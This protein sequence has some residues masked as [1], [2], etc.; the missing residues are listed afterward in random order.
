MS[1]A[2][3]FIHLYIP[4]SLIDEQFRGGWPRWKILNDRLIGR[5]AWFDQQLYTQGAM[6]GLDIDAHAARW[7]NAFPELF[8]GLEGIEKRW[9]TGVGEY[10]AARGGRADWFHTTAGATC[11]VGT[12]PDERISR[13]NVKET[14]RWL[15]PE[16]Y[17]AQNPTR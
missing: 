9:H 4:M 8:A 6:N 1:V 2:V 16:N 3:E 10:L 14:D 11:L 5:S 15:H 12:E 17:P 7:K 13:D